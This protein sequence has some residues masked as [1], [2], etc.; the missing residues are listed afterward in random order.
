MCP[1]E[2]SKVYGVQDLGGQSDEGGIHVNIEVI[3]G[4]DKE[5]CCGTDGFTVPTAN[6]GFFSGPEPPSPSDPRLPAVGHLSVVSSAYPLDLGS[7]AKFSANDLNQLDRTQISTTD[8]DGIIGRQVS[9]E[10]RLMASPILR[11][12]VGR[13]ASAEQQEWSSRR[14]LQQPEE[15]PQLH[16]HIPHPWRSPAAFTSIPRL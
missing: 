5:G 6:L 14:R 12:P 8:K 13:G 16:S 11:Y 1:A 10:F 2:W 7:P 4:Q 15:L 9:Q 3:Q